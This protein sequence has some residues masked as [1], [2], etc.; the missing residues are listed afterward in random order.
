[1]VSESPAPEKVLELKTIVRK[2]ISVEISLKNPINEPIMF[3]VVIK[4][5]GLIGDTSF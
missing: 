5:E 2:A 1:M 4:G 3:D